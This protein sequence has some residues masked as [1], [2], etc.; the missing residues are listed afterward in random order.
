MPKFHP[1]RIQLRL[2]DAYRFTLTAD[3]AIDLATRLVVGVDRL[4]AEQLNHD[5]ERTQP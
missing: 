3:E 1:A 2:G 5:H 4:R